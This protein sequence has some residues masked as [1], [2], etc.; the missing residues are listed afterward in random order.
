MKTKI[1][2]LLLSVFTLINW[3]QNTS[4][5]GTVTHNTK[6]LGG[7]HVIANNTKTTTITNESGEFTLNNIKPNEILTFSYL[8]Y[9][10]KSMKVTKNMFVVLE[11]DVSDLDLVVVSASRTAQKRKELPVAIS[12]ISRKTIDETNP[13]SVD[14]VLNQKSGVH[15]IDLGNEQHMMA[16]RQPISTKGLFLY[17]EDGIPIRPTGVFNHNALLEMNMS[18]TENIEIIRGPYSALYGSEAIGGAINFITQKPSQ[19]LTGTYGVR[20]D[21]LGYFRVDAKLSNTY[22]KNWVCS[23]RL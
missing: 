7:V 12:A 15:M 10:S 21:N 2:T 14:Q 11:A 3:S 1:L 5:S 13:S 18:A 17:L 20:A 9:E 6:T 4:V 19:K 23:K 8:G 16:I 22:K